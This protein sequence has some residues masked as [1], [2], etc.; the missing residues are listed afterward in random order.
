MKK[1][2]LLVSGSALLSLTILYLIAFKI[3]PPLDRSQPG[4]FSNFYFVAFT[5][6][7][8]VAPIIEEIGFRGFLTNNKVL[9]ALFLLLPPLIFILSGWNTLIFLLLVMVYSLFFI[10]KRYG[11]DLILDML[12]IASALCFSIHHLP[13][14]A[15]LTRSWL[16][17]LSISFS[18]GLI[19]S[20]IIINK[21]IWWA[22]LFHGAWN[23]LMAI[24]I[25]LSLQ[26]VS[27]DLHIVEGEDFKLEW[28]RVPFFESKVSSYSPEGDELQITNMNIQDILGIVNP[29]LLDSF[30]I[31]EPFMKYDIE[32]KSNGG[33]EIVKRDLIQ[34]LES[35]SLLVRKK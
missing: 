6:P 12:L 24:I 10:Y 25:L 3:T 8:L 7:V 19:L 1:N 21:S 30:A 20:W 31:S 29:S 4:S 34:A 9:Q 27:D 17:F 14:E 26:F 22:M 2:W 13:S 33:Y 28:R 15:S 16:P 11:Q 23:L 18:L 32:L 5:L 35:D